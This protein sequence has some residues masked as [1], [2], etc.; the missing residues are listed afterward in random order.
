MMARTKR[1]PRS[2]DVRARVT[3]TMKREIEA[4]AEREGHDVSDVVRR[5]LTMYLEGT[6]QDRKRGRR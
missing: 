5:A 1:E 3:P 2:E 4:Q 6:A